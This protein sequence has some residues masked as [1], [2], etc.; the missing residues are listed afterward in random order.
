MN[1][2]HL[3]LDLIAPSLIKFC[4]DSK[5]S[6]PTTS[7][8]SFMTQLTHALRDMQEICLDAQ[9]HGEKWREDKGNG[10]SA[11]VHV[12]DQMPSNGVCEDGMHHCAHRSKQ[13]N[14]GARL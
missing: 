11:D 4:I 5:H 12:H 2:I 7:T 10:M 13:L 3:H 6:C 8:Q 9:K 14:Q 1:Y